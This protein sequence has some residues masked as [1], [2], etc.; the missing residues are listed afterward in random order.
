L[1]S[2]GLKI[3]RL[4]TQRLFQPR[5]VFCVVGTEDRIDWDRVRQLEAEGA[6][7]VVILTGVPRNPDEA[8]GGMVEHEIG[9]EP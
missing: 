5:K 2:L 4:A 7:V 3:E 1:R 8:E 6:E 9:G